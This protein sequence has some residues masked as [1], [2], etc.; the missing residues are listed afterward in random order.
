MNLPQAYLDRM[1]GQLGDAFDAYLFAMD[2]PEKRAAH[3]NGL[4][5]SPAALGALRPDFTPVGGAGFLLPPGFAPGKDVL[6]CAGAYYVQELSAQVPADLFDLRP[7]MAVLDLCAAPGGKS[8][9]LAARVPQGVLFANEIVPNRAT[10]LLN[11]LERMGARN[12]VVTSMDPEKLI[13]A[14]GPVFDAVLVDA[15][16]AGEGMFRKDP[17]AIQAWSPEHVAACAKRQRAILATAQGALK[18]GG[19]LVYSTCSFSPAENEENVG[20]FLREYPDFE[21]VAERR[22]Y[23]HTSLGEGQYTAKLRRRGTA[24]DTAYLPPKSDK[25]P[26]AEA[27]VQAETE[28]LSGPLRLLPAGCARPRPG[29]GRGPAPDAPAAPVGSRRPPLPPRRDP[30]HRPLGLVRRDLCGPLP[31]PRQGRGWRIEKPPA[32]G[33]AGDLISFVTVSFSRQRYWPRCDLTPYYLDKD[34]RIEVGYVAAS[35]SLNATFFVP[36]QNNPDEPGATPGPDT[37]PPFNQGGFT[38]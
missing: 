17:A 34:D 29:H 22:L 26:L 23:P 32:Q 16:C 9:Q 35:P 27:F 36:T 31:G 1:K 20:W 2:Q 38:G 30:A 14:T 18:P 12:A 11:N 10:I 13:G 4:K 24:P 8:A 37:P 19:Q 5:M 33:P 15:P 3:T 25:A 21:L 28:G 6:H 7:T